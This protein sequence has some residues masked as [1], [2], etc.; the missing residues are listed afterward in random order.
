MQTEDEVAIHALNGPKKFS[1]MQ[2]NCWQYH[3]ERNQFAMVSP[4][5]R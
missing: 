3:D 5:T 4:V 1:L 2:L